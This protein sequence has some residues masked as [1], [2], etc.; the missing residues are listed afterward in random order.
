MHTHTLRRTNTRLHTYVQTHLLKY[1]RTHTLT[2]ILTPTYTH[3]SKA[4]RRQSVHHPLRI[5]TMLKCVSV[6][7]CVSV[8]AVC[9]WC[10]WV[11][12]RM[13]VCVHIPSWKL[14]HKKVMNILGVPILLWV[15]TQPNSSIKYTSK[16]S[17]L[18]NKNK[19]KDLEDGWSNRLH[20]CHHIVNVVNGYETAS[21]HI[22]GKQ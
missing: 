16:N 7:D 22:R 15:Y 11:C 9:E 13:C 4:T 17:T 6:K 8:Y 19:N 21:C 3:L 10:V 5:I 18:K 20:Q 12:E 14:L 1:I 2:H